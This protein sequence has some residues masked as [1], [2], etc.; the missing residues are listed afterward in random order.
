VH[1]LHVD[2]VC[3][4]QELV[5]VAD[6]LPHHKVLSV[7]LVD[8]RTSGR[9][10]LDTAQSRMQ[11]ILEKFKGE[12]WLA[13]TCSLLHLPNSLQAVEQITPQ[14][15]SGQACVVQKLDELRR[16]KAL[17]GAMLEEMAVPV[18][19]AACVKSDRRAPIALGAIEDP[20]EWVRT[21][22]AKEQ[23]QEVC[24]PG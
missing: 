6:W 11:P 7:G 22:Q 16:L 4:P 5:G 24:E 2:A 21:S 15:R 23:R 13:P 8:G 17:L 1:G 20:G 3:A 12:V 9:T 18:A 14:T 10:D 19:D